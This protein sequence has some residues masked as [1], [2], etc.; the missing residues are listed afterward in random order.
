MRFRDCS[1]HGDGAASLHT[2]LLNQTV[3]QL[4]ILTSKNKFYFLI[5]PLLGVVLI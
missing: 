4:L 1:S 2:A 5:F 3:N